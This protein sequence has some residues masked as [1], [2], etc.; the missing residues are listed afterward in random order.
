MSQKI[1][2][3]A[4]VIFNDDLSEERLIFTGKLFYSNNSYNSSVM[5]HQHRRLKGLRKGPIPKNGLKNMI[6]KFEEK[7]DL[8]VML[9]KVRISVVNESVGEDITAVVVSP[10]SSS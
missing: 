10:S 3:G 7:G 5:L 2:L 4:F 8:H 9:G 6:M 1:I